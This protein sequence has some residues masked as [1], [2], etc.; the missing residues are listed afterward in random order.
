MK[1]KY[2]TNLGDHLVI[3][4]ITGPHTYIAEVIQSDPLRVKTM[5]DGTYANL[6]EE[7]IIIKAG[8]SERIQRDDREHTRVFLK[9]RKNPVYSGL[10]SMGIKDGILRNMVSVK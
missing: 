2:T 10:K 8:H 3:G 7:V 4:M 5:E 6:V 1:K 9:S